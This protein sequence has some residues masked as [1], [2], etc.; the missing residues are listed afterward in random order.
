MPVAVEAHEEQPRKAQGD[1]DEPGAPTPDMPSSLKARMTTSPPGRSTTSQNPRTTSCRRASCCPGRAHPP[2]CR[3]R[4]PIS[5][6]CNRRPW[7]R[8]IARRS[9]IRCA[10]QAT[11]APIASGNSGGGS[12]RRRGGGGGGGGSEEPRPQ[13]DRRPEPDGNPDGLR[14]RAPRVNGPVYLPNVVGCEALTISLL[15]LL[16]GASD[17]DGD[18]LRVI[19]LSSSSGTL[20]Q[21]EDGSWVFTRDQGML[22]DV[23]LT[24]SHQRRTAIDPAGGVFQRRRS[25]ADHRHDRRRQSAGHALRGHHRRR[26]PVTTTSTPAKATT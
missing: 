21:T 16:A 15:V 1:E 6:A 26:R 14:N 19:G 2:R 17:P 18:T 7:S 20:T 23:T 13:P 10:R 25:A 12:G 3:N 22:G 11:A 8:S 4:R 9:A 24:Y 5:R